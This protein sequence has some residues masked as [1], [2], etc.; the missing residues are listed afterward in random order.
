MANTK[1]GGRH[2]QF[3]PYLATTLSILT[4][5]MALVLFDGRWEHI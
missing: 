2:G 3:L 5:N 1:H 4:E